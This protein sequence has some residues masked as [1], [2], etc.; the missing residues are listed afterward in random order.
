MKR[1]ALALALALLAG[2]CARKP[3]L[4]QEPSMSPVGS[5][6]VA[7]TDPAVMNI[8]M[9]RASTGSS[10]FQDGAANLFTDSRASKIGDVITVSIYINDKATFGNTSGR[11]Q[12]A[13]ET[14][15]FDW[16]F[17]LDSATHKVNAAGD[18][19]A[20]SSSNGQGSIDRSEKIQLAVAAVVTRVLPNG[21]LVISGTQEVRVNF[22]MRQLE[23]AGIVRPRDISANNLISYDKIAE[24]R[25]SYGGKGRIMDV[26]QPSWGQQIFDAAKPF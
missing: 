4:F 11:S 15:G 25:I 2:G 13:Q 16:T 9:P 8:D 7:R 17:G 22:E 5:G 24:A 6:F 12:T 19:N 1:L 21:N 18:I 26:Q 20:S 23:I 10:L 3:D 14:G